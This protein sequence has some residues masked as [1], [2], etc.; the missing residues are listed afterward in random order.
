MSFHPLATFSGIKGVP[1]L[2]LTRNSL[3]PLLS[4]EGDQVEIRVFRRLR[5][6]IADLARVTTSRAIGQ[7]VTL[8]PKAGFRSFSA[9]FADRGE[10]VRLLCTL[11]GLGAPLDDKARR[12]IAGQA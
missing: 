12:L 8:V 2:A 5:L 9:N 10:A 6:G 11:D 4:V 1:L 3:N 7:L